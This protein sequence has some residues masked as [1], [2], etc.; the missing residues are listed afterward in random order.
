MFILIF[1]SSKNS[2]ILLKGGETTCTL[3]IIEKGSPKIL[4]A[5]FSQSIKSKGDETWMQPKPSIH[6]YHDLRI[7]DLSLEKH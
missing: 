5:I 7:K 1:L 3:G 6:L 2:K 4:E